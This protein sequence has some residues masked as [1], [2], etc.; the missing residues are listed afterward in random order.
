MALT[1]F[2]SQLVAAAILWSTTLLAG[3]LPSFVGSCNKRNDG[4]HGHHHDHGGVISSS[5]GAER[6][7]DTTTGG[8]KPRLTTFAKVLSF[9]MN[10]GGGVLFATCFIHLLPEV[11]EC[12]ERVKQSS[13][14]TVINSKLYIHAISCRSNTMQAAG[15]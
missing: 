2:A 12:F 11:R 9:M 7:L 13:S 5:D 8:Q 4:D 15:C 1:L 3:F 6:A 14:E 10:F